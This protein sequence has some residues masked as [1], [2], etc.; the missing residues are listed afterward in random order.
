MEWTCVG[1]FKVPLD[2]TCVNKDTCI[3][4]LNLILGERYTKVLVSQV[5]RSY[6]IFLG[7]LSGLLA[8]LLLT[9]L[10]ILVTLLERKRLGG[11]GKGN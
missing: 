6:I 8:Y 10:L 1:N 2:L 9:V 4:L 5:L 7:P 3:V 11:A